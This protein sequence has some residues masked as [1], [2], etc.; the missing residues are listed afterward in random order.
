MGNLCSLFSNDKHPRSRES[1]ILTELER[2]LMPDSQHV[3]HC[4]INE[5]E[6]DIEK[7]QYEIKDLKDCFKTM[8]Q[9]I[10]QVKVIHVNDVC[11]INTTINTICRDME[12]LLNNDKH[13]K[14]DI[15]QMRIDLKSTKEIIMNQ[16]E[17]ISETSL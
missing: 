7:I 6:S 8:T 4:R 14:N 16:T 15:I 13:L 2:P 12:K 1:V 11:K 10:T 3:L 9:N 17:T 5:I